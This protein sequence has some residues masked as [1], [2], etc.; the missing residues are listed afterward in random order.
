MS[1]DQDVGAALLPTVGSADVPDVPGAVEDGTA[2]G[3]LV[4][5]WAVGPVEGVGMPLVL[6]PETDDVVVGAVERARRLVVGAT[7]AG[8]TTP[9]AGFVVWAVVGCTLR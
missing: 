7:G 2:A 6:V 3:A 9:P 4:V 5:G 8:W 1:S